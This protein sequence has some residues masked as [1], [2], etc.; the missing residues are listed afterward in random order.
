MD[1]LQ[2]QG[3]VCSPGI[4]QSKTPSSPY[5]SVAV[6]HSESDKWLVYFHL[7]RFSSRF[8]ITSPRSI[9]SLF[10]S[11]LSI[12]AFVYYPISVCLLDD[13][14][15]ELQRPHDVCILCRRGGRKNESGPTIHSV[16]WPLGGSKSF[17]KTVQCYKD[18][19]YTEIKHSQKS[20]TTIHF[21]D[22]KT[23]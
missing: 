14:F 12:C 21:V 17:Q 1:S 4:C 19:K 9:S 6:C 8:A 22:S 16:Y 10:L 2:N 7:Q 11:L 3:C 18:G 13:I 5:S 20:Q 15:K 23:V